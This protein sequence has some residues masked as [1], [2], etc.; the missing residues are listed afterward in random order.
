VRPPRTGRPPATWQQQQRTATSASKAAIASNVS[1]GADCGR[2]SGS[3]DR[4]KWA[5]SSRLSGLKFASVRCGAPCVV[6]PWVVPPW[7]A[8][9]RSTR[10]AAAGAECADNRC[11]APRPDW[12]VATA[13]ATRPTA[14]R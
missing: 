10:L 8:S 13:P 1:E 2:G 12:H 4:C 6:P 11:R 3:C 5:L 14:R 9:K 7:V